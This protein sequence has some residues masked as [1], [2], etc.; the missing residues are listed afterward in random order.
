MLEILPT[1]QLGVVLP[2]PSAHARSC[3][4]GRGRSSTRQHLH[5]EGMATL[6]EPSELSPEEKKDLITRNLQVS[7]L[8]RFLELPNRVCD[9][10]ER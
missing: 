4:R 10:C 7:T 5:C 1:Q 2:S 6:V 8:M 9:V 3:T